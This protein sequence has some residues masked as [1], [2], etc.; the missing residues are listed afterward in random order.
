MG[1]LGI[2]TSA[3]LY[4]A[5]GALGGFLALTMFFQDRARP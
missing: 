4:G 2:P 3:I 5:F 1:I